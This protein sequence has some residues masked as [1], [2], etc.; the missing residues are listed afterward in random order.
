MDVSTIA[1]LVLLGGTPAEH[2]IA[3]P[4]MADCRRAAETIASYQCLTADEFDERIRNV[5][6]IS[7]DLA[8]ASG[9]TDPVTNS[10]GEPEIKT[11]EGTPSALKRQV[12]KA[13][14]P[15]PEQRK[16]IYPAKR[17][18]NEQGNARLI[19]AYYR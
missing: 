8:P 2:I 5:N 11:R 17:G 10:N 1:F 3:M 13:L 6:N 12:R 14:D 7:S 19:V 9:P 16:T 15:Q 18:V 4:S